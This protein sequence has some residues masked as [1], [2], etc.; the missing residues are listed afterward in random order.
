MCMHDKQA[1]F[2]STTFEPK[3]TESSSDTTNSVDP[4]EV[5]LLKMMFGD[6]PFDSNDLNQS[7][8]LAKAGLLLGFFRP[9]TKVDKFMEDF[10]DRA[11]AARKLTN[12][13]KQS[14]I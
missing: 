1:Y 9:Q 7:R 6:L 11:L 3:E 14:F 2:Q 5:I 8:Q 10:A 13:S 12:K 4:P